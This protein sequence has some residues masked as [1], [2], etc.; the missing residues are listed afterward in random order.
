MVCEATGREVGQQGVAGRTPLNQ[1]FWHRR[2]DHRG[3][4]FV[5]LVHGD[6]FLIVLQDAHLTL[7]HHNL[8]AYEAIE[9]ASMRIMQ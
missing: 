8:F 5:D 4:Y 6:D 9:A 2:G 7:R 1:W 3:L